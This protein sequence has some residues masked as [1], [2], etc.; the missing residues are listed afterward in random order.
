M[1]RLFSNIIHRWPYVLGAVWAGYLVAMSDSVVILLFWLGGGGMGLMFFYWRMKQDRLAQ[2]LC[3]VS[4]GI[5]TVSIA[6]NS[7]SRDGAFKADEP[8]YWMAA[9][10]L[11]I[12]FFGALTVLI[13][14]FCVRDCASH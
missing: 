11:L 4:F 14:S 9:T 12:G 13:R 3:L 6:V 5:W 1:V 2:V 7:F 10:A 8:A